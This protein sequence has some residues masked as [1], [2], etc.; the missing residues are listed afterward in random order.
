MVQDWLG[1]NSSNWSAYLDCL[2]QDTSPD[3]LEFLVV[4]MATHFHIN[5]IQQG[6]FWSTKVDGL[7]NSDLTEVLVEDGLLF[8]DWF[9]NSTMP[10]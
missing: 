8:C 7:V 3:G 6:H 9:T 1:K 2:R 4:C 10:E 5:L